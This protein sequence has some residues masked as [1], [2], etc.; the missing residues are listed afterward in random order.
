MTAL[1]ARNPRCSLARSLEVLGEKWT[2]LV[3]REA[4]FG[5][6]RFAE[7]RE[8]LGVAPDVLT[9]RLATLVEV[10]VLSRRAYREPGERERDEYVLTE[11]GRALL[12][13]LGAFVHW[14]D[15][16]LPTGFGPATRYTDARGDTVRLAFVD[17]DG[18]E[19]AL[20]EIVVTRGPGALAG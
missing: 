20:D 6:T 1:T 16:Y 19:V 12:P 9:D 11:E 5:R 15:E 10:G 13:V 3:V 7:F 17:P 2:L 14:G 8:R 18:R 4:F